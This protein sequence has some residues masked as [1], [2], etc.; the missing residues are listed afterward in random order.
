[1]KKWFIAFVCASTFLL[2]Q[3]ALAAI[4]FKRFAHRDD[5]LVTVK[6]CECHASNSRI[7]HYCHAG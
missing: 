1:M 3:N 5:G 6:T 7:W 2:A 4:Q